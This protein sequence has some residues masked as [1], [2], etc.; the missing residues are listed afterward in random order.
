MHLTPLR[1]LWLLSISA[2]FLIVSFVL[3]RGVAPALVSSRDSLMVGLGFLIPVL[4]LVVTATF[5]FHLYT[6]S[7]NRGDTTTK[8]NHQ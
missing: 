2:A 7:R 8:E 1:L 3:L 4:W 5:A 6:R